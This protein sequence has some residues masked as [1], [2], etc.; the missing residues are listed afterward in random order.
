M[1]QY[2]LV[3]NVR[4]CIG[5]HNEEYL[6]VPDVMETAAI[7]LPQLTKSDHGW[8]VSMT[9]RY[10]Q[11]Q[12]SNMDA[13]Y[14]DVWYFGWRLDPL[15]YM[16]IDTY[17]NFNFHWHSPVVFPILQWTHWDRDNMAAIS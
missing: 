2:L 16:K 4:L 10:I 12:V 5:R 11:Y 1:P 6:A 13:K 8:A 15:R 7:L 14:L 17:E 3:P 9:A